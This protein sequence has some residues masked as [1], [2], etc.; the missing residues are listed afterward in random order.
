MKGTK[1]FLTRFLKGISLKKGN[2]HDSSKSTTRRVLLINFNE[3]E[4]AERISR[5]I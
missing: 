2:I 1:V 5:A 4:A 3:V